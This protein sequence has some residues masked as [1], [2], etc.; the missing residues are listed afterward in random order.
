MEPLV[1]YGCHGECISY[2][3]AAIVYYR[4]IS[5]YGDFRVFN[6]GLSKSAMAAMADGIT[7]TKDLPPYV[8]DRLFDSFSD[9][10]Y[11]DFQKAFDKVPHQ[12]LLLKLKA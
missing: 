4:S 1:I 11:L 7:S 12:R 10:I 3:V 5:F 6:D 8:L 9:I 2:A